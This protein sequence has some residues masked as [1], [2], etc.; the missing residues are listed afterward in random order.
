MPSANA[1]GSQPLLRTAP[2]DNR[3]QGGLTPYQQMMRDRARIA[4]DPFR[5]R[6][7]E[8]PFGANRTNQAPPGLYER[9]RPDTTLRRSP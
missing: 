1:P 3:S 2:G 4:R 7:Y 8:D 5:Q 9:L 6:L